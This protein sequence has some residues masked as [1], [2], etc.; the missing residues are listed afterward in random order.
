M[1]LAFVE[2][3]GHEYTDLLAAATRRR[4]RVALALDTDAAQLAHDEE[5]SQNE[6][7]DGDSDGEG[8][9]EGENGDDSE[10]DIE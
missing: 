10:E 7:G 8:E 1:L 6:S 5:G 9:D 3:L 2:E 4:G